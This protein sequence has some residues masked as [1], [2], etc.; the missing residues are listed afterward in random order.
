MAAFLALDAV[1][2]VALQ[3]PMGDAVYASSALLLT[4]G[5]AAAV[6]GRRLEPRKGWQLFAA[7]LLLLGVGDALYALPFDS[8]FTSSGVSPADG[9]YLLGSAAMVVGAFRLKRAH[10][11]E[12]DREALIDA[13]SVGVA[14]GI[15]LWQPLI[16]PRFTSGDV[17]TIGRF[18][19]GSY[20]VFDVVVVAMLCWLLLGRGRGSVTARLLVAGSL[21]LLVADLV[22]TVRVDHGTLGQGSLDGLDDLWLV[23][24]GLFF[25]AAL[26]PRA[27]ARPSVDRRAQLESTSMS[28]SRLA[29]SGLVLLAPVVSLAVSAV[30]GALGMDDVIMALVAAVGLVVLILVRFSDLARGELEARRALLDRERYFR[31][32]VEHASEALLVLDEECIV[33]D[34]SPAVRDV[35]HIEPALLVGHHPAEAVPTLDQEQMHV[36]LARAFA[37]PGDVITGELSYR[38]RQGEGWL[39]MRTT[40]LLHE[41]AVRGLVVNLHDVT[42]RRQVQSDLEHRAFTDPLTGLANRALFLDRLEQALRRRHPSDAAVLYC[43][44]DGFKGVNDRFGH[45][46]GD[47]VLKAVAARLADSVRLEDTVARLGGDEFAVL[48][49]G[50]G[51]PVLAVAVADR[52]LDELSRPLV[53]GGHPFPVAMSIGVASPAPG[54]RDADEL[55][56]RADAAMYAA[57]RAG[58]ARCVVHPRD[59]PDLVTPAGPA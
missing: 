2:L 18:V 15:L 37:A 35:L 8:P 14:A 59:S 20:P 28:L 55:L 47:R 9:A 16:Q 34:A 54:Q 13:L 49:E 4:A 42:A 19:S 41:P 48:V 27:A 31:S 45:A 36:M 6:W 1:A 26:H 53:V 3:T 40:N 5:F 58:G 44:L 7:G 38:T 29:M 52:V 23:S 21:M 25:L 30:D 50:E 10:V 57:K 51:A 17:S 46:D 22:Y 39:E 32:L 12:R 11:G 43:D 24:Y 33:C 56:R